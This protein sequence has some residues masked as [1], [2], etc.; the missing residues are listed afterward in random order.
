MEGAVEAA[1]CHHR[2]GVR[3]RIRQL[4]EHPTAPTP[5]QQPNPHVCQPT[6]VVLR[7]ILTVLPPNRCYSPLLVHMTAAGVHQK[8]PGQD[9]SRQAPNQQEAA[10]DSRAS[11]DRMGALTRTSGEAVGAGG[12]GTTCWWVG[13]GG[14][15]ALGEASGE[16]RAAARPAPAASDEG[17]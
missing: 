16:G 13:R 15:P 3:R 1:T 12:G 11:P 14:F 7:S 4:Y 8:Q 10:Q 17:G 5:S 2:M 6:R 9:W